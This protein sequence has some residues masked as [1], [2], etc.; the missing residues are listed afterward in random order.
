MYY[1]FITFDRPFLDLMQFGPLVLAASESRMMLWAALA[2]W[3][4]A[5]S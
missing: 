2:G 4:K 5:H 3:G 1:E